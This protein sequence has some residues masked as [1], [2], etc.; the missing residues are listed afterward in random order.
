MGPRSLC[1]ISLCREIALWPYKD[2]CLQFVVLI[3]SS[4]AFFLSLLFTV[5]LVIL[6]ILYLLILYFYS[7][8]HHCFILHCHYCNN[9]SYIYHHVPS[10]ICYSLYF[11]NYHYDPCQYHYCH[12]LHFYRSLLHYHSKS[13]HCFNSH[14]SL[15][16]WQTIWWCPREWQTGVTLGK[17]PFPQIFDHTCTCDADA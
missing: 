7:F 13:R 5:L 2:F 4:W 1:E 16:K 8:H 12:R 3:L 14:S 15:P 6:F 17:Q 11:C 9:C 10:V